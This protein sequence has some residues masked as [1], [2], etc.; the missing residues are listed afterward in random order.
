MLYCIHSSV[1][2]YRKKPCTSAQV[3]GRYNSDVI[4]HVVI[5]QLMASISASLCLPRPNIDLIDTQSKPRPN[6]DL[7]DTQS[8]IRSVPEMGFI[9]Y[10]RTCKGDEYYV[11]TCEI[12]WKL[13]RAKWEQ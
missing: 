10:I 13:K 8:K 3:V 12:V 7:I 11:A 9:I 5:K 1:W 4:Y 6:I 2:K